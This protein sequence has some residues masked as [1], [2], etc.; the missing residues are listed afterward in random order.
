[1]GKKKNPRKQKIKKSWYSAILL[2][3]VNNISEQLDYGSIMQI[4]SW[5]LKEDAIIAI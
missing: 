3:G 1:M 5:E 4:L 2:E